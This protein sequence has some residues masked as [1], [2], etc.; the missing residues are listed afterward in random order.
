MSPLAHDKDQV[1]FLPISIKIM[2]VW[3]NQI[4]IKIAKAKLDQSVT[5]G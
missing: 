4:D 3:R 5:K 2:I 1:T